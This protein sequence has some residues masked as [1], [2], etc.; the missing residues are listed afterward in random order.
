[1]NNIDYYVLA[2]EDT[3]PDEKQRKKIDKI[4]AIIT[5]TKLPFSKKLVDIYLISKNKKECKTYI[6]NLNQDIRELFN[7]QQVGTEIQYTAFLDILGFSN[8]IKTKITND[9]LAEEFHDTFNEIIEYIQYEKENKFLIDNANYLKNIEIKYSWISDTFVISVE[10]INEIEKD[11]ENIIKGMMLF[12]LSMI[13][14]S[15]HHFMALKFGFIVRGAISSKYSCITNNFILGEG[16]AEASKLEKEIAIHPRVIFEQNIISHEI[17][18]LISRHYRDN[19]L[20]YITKDCDGCYFVNYLAI[21]QYIPPMI[22]KIPR[23]PDN[24]I[25]ETAIEQK[26]NVIKKYQKIVQDGSMIADEKIKAKYI[27]LNN[28]LGRIL[29]KDEFQKRL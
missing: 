27:W 20:N 21:L 17:Y 7:I 15:I 16:V 29:L 26:V 13:V 14:A 18:E 8:H 2:N 25:K 12:R 24:K 5:D 4:E 11:D 10:Y 9:Y 23:I 19:D 6:E 22:G 1:M 3:I 28:Y